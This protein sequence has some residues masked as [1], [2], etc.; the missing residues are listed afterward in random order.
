ME[1]RQFG[2]V[3][4][5]GPAG[6]HG[7]GA[8]AAELPEHGNHGGG[9]SI[10]AAC[11]FPGNPA[12]AQLVQ[13]ALLIGQGLV[14]HVVIGGGRRSGKACGAEIGCGHGRIPLDRMRRPTGWAFWGQA[15]VGETAGPGTAGA[16]GMVD[17][18]NDADVRRG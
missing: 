5:V 6:L 18:P 17:A 15:G 2:A 8:R 13:I 4:C 16:L 11:G 9:L 3:G 10:E 7:P 14:R 12:L 1:G